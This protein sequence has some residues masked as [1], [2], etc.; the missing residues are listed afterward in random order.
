[1]PPLAQ[2][3]LCCALDTDGAVVAAELPSTPQTPPESPVEGPEKDLSTD[4]QIAQRVK[5]LGKGG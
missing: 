2:A 5:S 3:F 4:N 1:M